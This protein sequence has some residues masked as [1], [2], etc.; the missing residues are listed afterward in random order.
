MLCLFEHEPSGAIEMLKAGMRVS[1]VARY[2]CSIP[3]LYSA[4]AI[5]TR[6]LG[7]LKISAGLVCQE[8]RPALR[9]N[10]LSLCIDDIYIDDTRSGQLLS[11]PD[12]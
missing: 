4:S 12:K 10:L 8:W 7:Q 1:G 11:M 6:L 2:H 9:A 3:Q 5:V